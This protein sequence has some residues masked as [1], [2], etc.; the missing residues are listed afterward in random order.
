MT[1]SPAGRDP[2]RPHFGFTRHGHP[3]HRATADYHPDGTAW[4]R[5]NKSVALAINR[6]VFTMNTF[7]LFN[8]LALCSLPAVLTGVGIISKGTFPGWLV[9]ASF[10]SLIAWVAQ[11]YLQLVLL[12]ALGVGQ[13]LQSQAQ[14]A[15]AAKQF[16]DVEALRED[17]KTALDRLDTRTEGGLAD[18]L[19]AVH[20]AITMTGHV[21][22]AVAPGHAETAPAQVPANPEGDAA[23]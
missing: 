20:A 11:T 4:Q 22:D 12:P 1:A 10:I 21:L 18:V 13:S 19:A 14:D 17:V 5:F 23:P 8:L 6:G 9:S 16:E 7:W 3:V 2:Q 15:R